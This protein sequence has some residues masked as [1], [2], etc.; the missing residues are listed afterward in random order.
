[1]ETADNLPIDAARS[2]ASELVGN[3]DEPFVTE[4]IAEECYVDVAASS[5]ETSEDLEVLALSSNKAADGF[6]KQPCDHSVPLTLHPDNQS[7]ADVDDAPVVDKASVVGE[8]EQTRAGPSED[9]VALL[10]QTLLM[11]IQ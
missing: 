11:M 9:E 7:P 5:L 4:Q 2:E 8:G 3:R 1:L 6:N 10:E